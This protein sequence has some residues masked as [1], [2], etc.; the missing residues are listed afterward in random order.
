MTILVRQYTLVFP[1]DLAAGKIVKAFCRSMTDVLV[2]GL[3]VHD[4]TG[5]R[6]AENKQK[7]L[8][9]LGIREGDTFIWHIVRTKWSFWR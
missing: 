5:T 8:L 4:R 9:Q 3:L 2:E 7:T 1:D 6:I